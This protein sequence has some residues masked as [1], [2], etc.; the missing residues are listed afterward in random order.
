M[1]VKRV[2][3]LYR[4]EGLAEGLMVRR[5]KRKRLS[6]AV[7]LNPL[8]VRPNQEWAMDFVSDALATGRAADIHTDRQLY[9]RIAGH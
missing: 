7:P 4:A 3:R 6:R 8:L 9:E 1:D 5:M 2:H